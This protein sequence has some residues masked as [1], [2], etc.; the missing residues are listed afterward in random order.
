MDVNKNIIHWLNISL[1]FLL[2]MISLGGATRLTNSG[3]SM[4]IWKPVTGIIPPITSIEWNESFDNYKNFP[5]FKKTKPEMGLSDYKYIYYWE[6]MHRL[7]GR[8]IGFLFVIPFIFFLSKGYLNKILIKKLIFVFLLG[9]VQGFIGWFMVRSGLVDNPQVSHYRL[10]MHLVI[11]FF[12]LGYIYNIKLSLIANRKSE[13]LHYNYFNILIN[14]IIGLVFIQIIYGA[15]NAGLKTVETINTFPF[16]GNEIIP[17]DI[18]SSNDTWRVF[19]ENHFAVQLVHR[20][21]A[22]IILI[23]SVHFCLKI[24]LT[25]NRINYY[26]QYLMLIVVF[27]C[28][29]GILTLNAHAPIVFS[30]SHQLLASVL[31]LLVFKIKHILKFK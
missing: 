17:L 9:G 20:Y 11:A 23:L 2:M 5:Q 15:F 27:Q 25:Q 3:L 6:Y 13:V 7:L 24:N 21:L 1:F 19:F 8:F 29:L 31:I 4:V 12:I 14:I 26:A 28:L 30:L 10:A 18:L 16:F 22:L